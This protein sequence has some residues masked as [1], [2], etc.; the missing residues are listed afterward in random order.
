[1]F[2]S[3]Y[4]KV[5]VYVVVAVIRMHGHGS[6]GCLFFIHI[7]MLSGTLDF[8]MFSTLALQVL[9]AKGSYLPCCFILG[10]DYALYSPFGLQIQMH[11]NY[12]LHTAPSYY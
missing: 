10:V 12:Q 7:V 3:W 9:L 6:A 2:L 11:N 4:H 5:V 8:L 1:M